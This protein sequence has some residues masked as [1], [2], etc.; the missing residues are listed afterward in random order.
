MSARYSYARRPVGR[1]TVRQEASHR[2]RCFRTAQKASQEPERRRSVPLVASYLAGGQ[3]GYG[4]W[5]FVLTEMEISSSFNS[6]FSWTYAKTYA[7]TRLE[8]PFSPSGCRAEAYRS[9]HPRFRCN[10]WLAL[11]RTPLTYSFR[12]KSARQS[13]HRSSFLSPIPI[14]QTVFGAR[15]SESHARHLVPEGWMDDVK[16]WNL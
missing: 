4:G 12:Y 11:I 10:R 8:I 5:H 6:I 16:Y 1:Q 3:E 9:R 15:L 13:C 14:D 2:S 7:R